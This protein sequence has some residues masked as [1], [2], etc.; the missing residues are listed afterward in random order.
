MAYASLNYLQ[1]KALGEIMEDAEGA[2]IA[3]GDPILWQDVDA[4]APNYRRGFSFIRYR[5]NSAAYQEKR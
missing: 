1:V 2:M 4:S 5:R 3:D